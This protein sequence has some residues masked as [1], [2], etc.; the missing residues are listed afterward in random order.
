[1]VSQFVRRE[2]F[3]RQSSLLRARITVRVKIPRAGNRYAAG[4]CS[5]PFQNGFLCSQILQ[6]SQQDL[7]FEIPGIEAVAKQIVGFLIDLDS[8]L[9]EVPILADPVGTLKGSGCVPD[10]EQKAPLP[11]LKMEDLASESQP[12]MSP[13]GL[14]FIGVHINV[15]EKRSCCRSRPQAQGRPEQ[16]TQKCES[17][18]RQVQAINC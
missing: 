3:S 16:Q 9:A 2:D 12:Y 13:T 6:F 10:R 11:I 15:V 17:R 14:T 8:M 1:L 18:S 4:T 7:A 5:H